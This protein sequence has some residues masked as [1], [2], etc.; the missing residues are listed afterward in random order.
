MDRVRDLKLDAT[1]GDLVIEDS[2]LALV[3][4]LDSIVQDVR[5][6]LGFFRGEWFLDQEEG[7]PYY[8]EILVK[9]PNPTAVREWFR[10]TIAGTPGI[11]EVLSLDLDFD[12]RNRRLSVSFRASTDLGLLAADTVT[13]PVVS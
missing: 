8:E 2:D 6:R 10:R 4:D 5:L 9:N 12:R 3:G 11:K 7:V 1:T 13:L